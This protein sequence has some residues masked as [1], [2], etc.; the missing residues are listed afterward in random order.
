MAMKYPTGKHPTN[1]G[2]GYT[3]VLFALEYASKARDAGADP[4][5]YLRELMERIDGAN[6]ARRSYY[7]GPAGY[8]KF[9]LELWSMEAL[10]VVS[11]DPNAIKQLRVEHG[12]PRAAYAARILDLYIKGILT[13]EVFYQDL[14]R[15]YKLALIT[16]EEDLKLN[17]AGLRSKMLET[18]EARWGRVGIEVVNVKQR[19]AAE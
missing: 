6:S 10:R 17:A 11:K 13:E 3:F 9:K 14:D 15:L 7:V 18:P 12:S 8:D 1:R 2:W 19:L 16:L 4:N 5:C